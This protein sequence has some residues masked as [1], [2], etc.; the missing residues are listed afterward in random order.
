M[1]NCLSSKPLEEHDLESFNDGKIESLSSKNLQEGSS[2][3]KSFPPGLERKSVKK[4]APIGDKRLRDSF[5]QDAPDAIITLKPKTSNDLQLIYNSLSKHFIFKNISKEQ[6]DLIMQEMKYY[7]LPEGSYIIEQ[8]KPGNNFFVIA[9]GK[10]E[11]LVN[12]SRVNILLPGDSFGEM[13]LLQDKPRSASVRTLEMSNLW[14]VDRVTFRQAVQA[15]NAANYAQNKAFIETVPMFQVLTSLQK[16]LLLTSISVMNY[17]ESQK[18]VNEGETGDLF[19]IIKEGNVTCTRAGGFL[20]NMTAGEYFGEQALL[21][22]TPRTATITAMGDTKCLVIGRDDLMKALGSHFSQIIY[23]NSI[24]MA[25]D[26]SKTLRQ[27]TDIQ[28]KTLISLMKVTTFEQNE[29]VI[30]EGTKINEKFYVVANGKLKNPHNQIVADIFNVLGEDDVTDNQN[31]Y[32]ELIAVGRVDIA[33]INKEDFKNIIGG[34]LDKVTIDEDV[35]KVLKKVN[36]FH[37]L[38]QEKIKTLVSLL[39][40]QEYQEGDIIFFQGIPGDSFYVVKS[41]RVEVIKNDIVLRTINKLDYFGE[42][43]ILFNELRTATIKAQS[44]VQ[45]WVLHKSDFFRV[46][47]E[48]M[49]G[50]LQKR[51]QLQ[52]D[53]ITLDDLI[54]V[55]KLGHGMFGNVFLSAHKTKKNLYALKTIDRKK[56]DNEKV[57]DSLILERKILMQLDHMLILKLVKTFKDQKRLYFLLEYVRGQDLFDV[58]RELG[59]VSDDDSRFYA[60]C[61]IMIFEHLHERDIVYRDLKP[62]NVMIDEEGYPKLIDFGTARIVE[63]RTYTMI[64]TPHYMAPEVILGKGYGVSADYW[65]L[66]IMIYEFICG[67]VPFGESESDSYAIYEKVL[68][69]KISY[70]NYAKPTAD[71][72]KF[73]EQMLSRNPALRSGGSIEG[74]KMHPW[75]KNVDWEGL[76]E[77]KVEPPY[78]PVIPNLNWE[79]E[80]AFK[81]VKNISQVIAYEERG[82]SYSNFKPKNPQ[83]DEEF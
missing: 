58:I 36:L 31:S 37:S 18:I 55:K 52:D 10:V 61:M 5:T 83:W 11:I 14:G 73:I 25:F 81:N 79:I 76:F 22:G 21:Y 16:E 43:S 72:K 74:L 49:R 17:S 78:V 65:S 69:G 71:S 68:E 51:I 13:A 1:G 40:I 3:H 27:L 60:S 12:N 80:K 48:R 28:A 35:L 44:K 38:S 41:G 39:K 24:R 57:Q 70:A 75:L 26:K 45:C 9:S 66:G 47:D 15:I 50:M 63:G 2:I 82:G 19:Y 33:S 23:R 67:G 32:E 62:E 54:I 7:S 4:R 6:Q 77:K 59:L 42:R 8:G 46:I 20:R 64:G 34:N 53:N 30:K 56:I 29:V